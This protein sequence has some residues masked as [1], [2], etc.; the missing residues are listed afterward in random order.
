MTVAV[1][2]DSLRLTVADDGKGFDP[3]AARRAG[4]LGLSSMQ[5]RVRLVRGTIAIH[6]SIGKGTR[7]E[8]IVPLTWKEPPPSSGPAP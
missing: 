2:V 5:E 3:E 7:V 6:S 8:L 4:G 1:P